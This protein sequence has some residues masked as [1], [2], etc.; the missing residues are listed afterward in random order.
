[1]SISY[2]QT[3]QI[4]FFVNTEPFSQI[5]KHNRAIFLELEVTW[6]VVSVKQSNK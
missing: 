4:D 2:K 5:T 1:V 3:D 6:H